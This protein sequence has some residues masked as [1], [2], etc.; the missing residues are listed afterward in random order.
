M[1][2]MLKANA[3]ILRQSLG[4]LLKRLAKA[5]EPIL[6]EKNRQ[7][8]AVLVSVEDY[9]KRFVDHALDDKRKQMIEKIKKANI[10]LPKGLTSL[11]LIQEIR[12]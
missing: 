11:D 10:P 4:Q 6:I 2:V 9:Q 8:V 1:V 12:S 7:P 3:L 5:S